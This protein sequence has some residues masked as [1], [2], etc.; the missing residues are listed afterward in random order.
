M[1]YDLNKLPILLTAQ[2][3]S[4]LLGLTDPRRLNPNRKPVAQIFLGGKPRP[5]F[6]YPADALHSAL[7]VNKFGSD[8]RK[9]LANTVLRCEHPKMASNR[10]SC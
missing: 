1:H 4:R 5:L 7:C 10:F 2:E 6:E 3:L 9:P 8:W